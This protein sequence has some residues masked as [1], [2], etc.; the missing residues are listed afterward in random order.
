MAKRRKRTRELATRRQRKR[1][2]EKAKF[3]AR[4]ATAKEVSTSSTCGVEAIA[5]RTTTGA[6]DPAGMNPV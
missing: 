3:G 2:G 4:E 1:I 5:K 6:T